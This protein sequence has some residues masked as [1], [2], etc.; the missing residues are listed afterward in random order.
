MG[1]V[2]AVAAA[3]F[4]GRL[5]LFAGLELYADEAYYW[6]WSLR[7]AFGYFDHPPMVAYLAWLGSLLPGEAGLRTPFALCGALVVVFAAHTARALSD[8]PR[9]PLAA[10]LLAATAPMLMLGGALALPDAP[11]EAAFAAATWLVLMARGRAWLLIGL[12]AGLALLSKYSAG[13]LALSVLAAAPLDSALRA[14]LRT[15]WPWLGALLAALIFA[16]CLAWNV[17]HDFISIRFQFAHA[18]A[19]RS[20]G[21]IPD[22]LGGVLLGVGPIVLVTAALFL[23]RS[24]SGPARRLLAVTAVPLVITGAIALGGQVHA[25]WPAL[26]YPGLCA[27]AGAFA[28]TLGTKVARIVVGASVALGVALAIGYAVEVRV[29]R[30]LRPS[31]S[32]IERFHGWRDVVAEVRQAVGEPTPFVAPSNYQVAAELAYYGGFRRFGATFARRSQFNIWNDVPAAG[33]RVVMVGLQEPSPNVTEKI[34]G[35]PAAPPAKV[36]SYFAGA[37]IRTLWITVPRGDS[38]DR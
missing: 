34:L 11:L 30:L 32:P 15:R 10:A 13:L 33:E 18:L 14:E 22:F 17:A 19:G 3:A 24:R 12:A 5:A 36:E 8:R 28:A 31:S 21:A 1:G 23:A 4:L 29:P 9:A 2:Y 37:R 6:T 7:P 16:P 35:R 27:A 20:A 25:N 26:V 38:G